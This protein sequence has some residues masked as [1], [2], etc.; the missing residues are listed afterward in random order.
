MAFQFFKKYPNFEMNL[1][2]IISEYTGTTP[3]KK[4]MSLYHHDMNHD[5]KRIM[6]YIAPPFFSA[7]MI[8]SAINIDKVHEEKEAYIYGELTGAPYPSVFKG[9]AYEKTFSY[10]VYKR[11]HCDCGISY[12]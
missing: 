10:E 4:M 1:L 11:V 3:S 7:S 6:E 9:N 2:P 8:L 5:F 12:D